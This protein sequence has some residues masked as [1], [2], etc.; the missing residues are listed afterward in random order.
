MPVRRQR[1]AFVHHELENIA[2]L[3]A[4]RHADADF[5]G[6]L[7]YEEGDYAVDSDDSEDER[8]GRE[9]AEQGSDRSWRG[10]CVGQ[11]RRH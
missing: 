6:A 5:A 3:G 4:Q 7:A 9:G 10:G 1:K 11:D 8:E 2:A